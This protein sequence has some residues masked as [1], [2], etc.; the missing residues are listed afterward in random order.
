MCFKGLQ[1][2]DVFKGNPG[3]KHELMSATR[4]NVVIDISGADESEAEQI[5]DYTVHLLLQSSRQQE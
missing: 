1:R 4:I 3:Q 5:I 2:G